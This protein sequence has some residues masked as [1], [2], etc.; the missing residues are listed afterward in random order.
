MGTIK[1]YEEDASALGRINAWWMAFHMAQA[2]FFG[3]GFES[4]IAPSFAM[5][6]PEP[7]RVHDAH[8]IYFEVLGEH[9]FVGLALLLSLLLLTWLKC[10]A[11]RRIVRR[12]KQN[13]WAADLAQMLQVSLIAYMVGGA[14]LGL[15]YFDYFYHLIALAVTAHAIVIRNAVQP[16]NTPAAT[17]AITASNMSGAR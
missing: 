16:A 4:F 9:G 12:T 7:N 15:A 1:T 10:S 11:M 17:P 14:F 2:R 5:Y 8:S 3:G 6:A 13:L